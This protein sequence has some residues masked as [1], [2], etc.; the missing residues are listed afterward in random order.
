MRFGSLWSKAVSSMAS[1]PTSFV[2]TSRIDRVTRLPS[3]LKIGCPILVYKC[4]G[5][6]SSG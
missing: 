1:T 2:V 6:S 4:E 5:D 3:F